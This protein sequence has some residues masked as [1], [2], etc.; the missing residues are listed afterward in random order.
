MAITLTSATK[1]QFPASAPPSESPEN[2]TS[3][4][5]IQDVAKETLESVKNSASEPSKSDP[6]ILPDS[7]AASGQSATVSQGKT[8]ETPAI[9]D[10]PL[11]KY[12]N[13]LN[14]KLNLDPLT[15]SICFLYFL[16]KIVL[17]IELAL[18]LMS[19]GSYAFYA[20]HEIDKKI[21]HL[22]DPI[23]E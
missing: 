14:T 18:V 22:L 9:S 2:D 11:D 3:N 12:I 5:T 16:K 6:I 10:I 1:T 19:L 17:F 8:G 23:N 20:S 13:K 4:K 7:T 21:K 15:S